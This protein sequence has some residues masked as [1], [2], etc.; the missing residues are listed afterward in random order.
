MIVAGERWQ[1]ELPLLH[2]SGSGDLMT[3]VLGKRSDP[4]RF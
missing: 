4:E 3:L 2:W 1:R